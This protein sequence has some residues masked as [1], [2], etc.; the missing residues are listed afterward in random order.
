YPISALGE[1]KP[2][3]HQIIVSLKEGIDDKNR[4]A[5]IDDIVKNGGKVGDKLDIINGF[6]AQVPIDVFSSM[7]QSSLTGQH[8]VINYVELDGKVTIQQQ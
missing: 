5:I 8:K 3:M 4:Q 1:N 7:Q 2:E 6:V